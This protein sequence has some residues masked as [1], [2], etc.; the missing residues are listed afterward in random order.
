MGTVHPV[1]TRPHA[2][3]LPF[4]V[5]YSGLWCETLGV[6]RGTVDLAL[7]RKRYRE[8]A[9]QHH[10]DVGGSHQKMQEVNEAYRRA[11]AEIP[12]AQR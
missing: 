6:P 1:G 7:V 12:A 5:A 9:K 8:L 2:E 11:L 4:A 3:S 10:P